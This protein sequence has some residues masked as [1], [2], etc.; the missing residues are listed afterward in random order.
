MANKIL[1]AVI[2]AVAIALYVVVTRQHYYELHQLAGQFYA[3]L[4]V[5]FFALRG[6]AA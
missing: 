1:A 4:T 3:L 5:A 2:L 6:R